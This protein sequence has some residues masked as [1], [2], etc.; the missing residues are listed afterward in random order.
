VEWR[1]GYG[2]VRVT[3][4]VSGRGKVRGGE[5]KILSAGGEKRGIISLGGCNLYFKR[6]NRPSVEKGKGDKH[7][8]TKGKRSGMGGNEGERLM[9][10]L[11]NHNI[12][13]Q[14]ETG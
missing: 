12:G 1:G 14:K 9:R 4:T 6:I 3:V 2:L 11:V 8:G 10:S 7:C 5:S 13:N